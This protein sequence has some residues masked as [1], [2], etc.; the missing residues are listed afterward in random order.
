MN[1]IIDCGSN[2]GQ[3]LNSIKQNYSIKFDQIHM[4]E[5]NINCFEILRENFS[6]NILHNKAVY[7]QNL[8]KRL[9]VEYCTYFNK[10][11]GGSTNILESDFERPFYLDDSRIHNEP[12]V[13]S[14]LVECIDLSEYI[15]NNF[16]KNDF[17]VLKLDIEGAEFEVLDKMISDESLNYINEIYVEWHHRMRK[18]PQKSESF[19]RDIF[20]QLNIK[21]FQWH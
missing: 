21:Y 19:Y 3:G 20:L 7:N 14:P 16:K 1:V 8:I 5:P 9:N 15:V 6:E 13:N 4:F 10:N 17:I 11:V 12:S 18:T 2:Y